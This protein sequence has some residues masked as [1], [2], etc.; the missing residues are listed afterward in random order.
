MAGT[1][2]EVLGQRAVG[3]QDNFFQL[4]GHSLLATRVV[5]G[6]R[7]RYGVEIPVRAVF[8]APTIAQLAAE[9]K[10]RLGATAPDLLAETR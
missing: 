5:A 6:L 1:W 8:E 2:C 7:H 10:A 9:V 3:V 4:G